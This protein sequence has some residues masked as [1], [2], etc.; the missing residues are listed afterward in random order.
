GRI[1]LAEKNAEAQRLLILK[2]DGTVERTFDPNSSLGSP[3]DAVQFNDEFY[4]ADG[5]HGLI[6]VSGSSYSS[7]TPDGPAAISDG[8]MIMTGGDLW[9]APGSVTTQWQKRNRHEGISRFTKNQW[10]NYDSSF[11]AVSD[12]ISV[13]GDRSGGKIWAGS[14]GDGLAE[15]I[16]GSTLR[17]YKENSFIRPSENV[18]GFYGVTGLAFDKD[19]N[20]W[21]SN[22]GA[23]PSL[24]V[25][26]PDGN[27]RS[28]IVPGSNFDFAFSRIIIDDDNQKWIISPKNNGLFLFNSGSSVDNP[29]DDRWKHYSTGTGNGNLPDNNVLSIAMD[30]SGFIWVGTARGIGIIQCSSNAFGNPGCDA[31]LPIVQ[32]DNFAGYLFSNEQ[33]QCITVD[34][35]D[36][37]WIGTKNG[38]WLI[39]KYG[40][41]TLYHFTTANSFLLDNDVS[42]IAVDPLTG[43]VF[44]ETTKG[45]CSF[46]A[47]A[48]GREATAQK[49]LVFPNPVPPTFSGTIAIRGL[50]ENSI[51]KIVEIDGRLVYQT[52]SQG[53]TA[54]WNGLNYKGGKVSAGVYLILTRDDN[55]KDQ[56]STKIVIV[57]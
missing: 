39:S 56:V 54:S 5:L 33:V 20:L 9:V 45:I 46:R 57:K 1:I 16:P 7:F 3:V 17:L 43:E 19:N 26:K 49:V 41:K 4:L 2:T 47:D 6:Q 55:G 52:R 29:A 23:S 27:T 31:I 32:Q 37:K 50:P 28:F 36:R 21:I 48:T 40:D 35:A 11:A 18:A 12:I 42:N 15:F 34:G 8:Q 25:R 10:I 24:V 38:V 13:A 51:V 14:Y 44:F 22:Y 30:K 53:T